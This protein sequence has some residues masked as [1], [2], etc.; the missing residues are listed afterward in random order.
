MQIRSVKVVL[1]HRWRFFIADTNLLTT[2]GCFANNGLMQACNCVATNI[3][4]LQLCCNYALCTVNT[5]FN[6]EI[7]TSTPGAGSLVQ[8]QSLVDFC[9]VSAELFRSVLDVCVERV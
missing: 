1:D 6:T 9:R 5:F 4:L 7:C 2:E 8:Q 3:A